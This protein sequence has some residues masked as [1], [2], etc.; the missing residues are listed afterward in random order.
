MPNL[1]AVYEQ[2]LEHLLGPVQHFLH[3]P[4]VSEVMI[5]GFDE[6]YIERRGKLE[7]TEVRFQN[8]DALRAAMRNVAQFVGK[9]LDP[10]FLSLEARLPNGSRVHIMQPPASRKGLCATIRKFAHTP[11]SLY[12]MVAAGTLSEQAAEVLD[13]CVQLGKN[14]VVSGGTSSG[15][16]TLLNTLS[17]RI[18][19]DE[20]IL[21][22]E[23]STELQLQQEHVVSFEA[24]PPDRH[25]HGGITIR[26]LFKASLRMRPDRIV[27]GEIR[28]GEALDM[29][30]A[31]TSGH[32]G[33]MSTCHANNP[34]DALNRLETMALMGGVEMPLFAIRSQLASALDLIIQIVRSRDGHRRITHITEVLELNDAGSITICD[35]FRVDMGGEG[36][37]ETVGQLMHT[38]ARPRFHQELALMGL[39]NQVRLSRPLWFAE[40]RGAPSL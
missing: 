2:T 9:R 13:L 25:G 20:R 33:S 40:D 28:G 29:I 4:S 37:I 34:R 16:T 17:A 15:K 12:D 6:I 10:S 22:L 32:A 31:M 30:Q 36:G 26:E 1:I 39:A 23:D 27:I 5:N 21:V 8:E 14:I 24:Q 19:A 35:L 38:G 3:D 7:R 18:S 11:L